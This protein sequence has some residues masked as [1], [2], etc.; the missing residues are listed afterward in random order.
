[1]LKMTQSAGAGRLGRLQGLAEAI[2]A[3]AQL[4]GRKL[5]WVVPR[6]AMH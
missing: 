6:Q 4:T 2:R 1:M 3:S 5:F